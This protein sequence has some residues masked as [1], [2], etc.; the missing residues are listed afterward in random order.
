MHRARSTL[1]SRTFRYSRT[2]SGSLDCLSFDP[3]NTST[4]TAAG[5]MTNH[6]YDLVVIHM[7]AIRHSGLNVSSVWTTMDLS[8][9]EYV[10]VLDNCAAAPT[11]FQV[12]YK[13]H[14][15]PLTASLSEEG[16]SDS[17]SEETE[18]YSRTVSV[19]Y[20]LVEDICAEGAV[21]AGATLY[22]CSV[23]SLN[24]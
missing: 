6:S 13:L 3:T 12:R 16:S 10:L 18:A 19:S 11:D 4:L 14:R 1:S 5:M 23:T 24:A 9:I 7:A 8:S 2:I 17:N 21:D 22:R 15:K 20:T